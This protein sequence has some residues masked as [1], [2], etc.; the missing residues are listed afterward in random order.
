MPELWKVLPSI[1]NRYGPVP[2][3]AEALIEP[4]SVLHVGCVAVA[5]RLKVLTVD[6]KDCS[7]YRTLK[8]KVIRCEFPPPD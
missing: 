4:R 1:E 8:G 7:V 3:E 6:R 2:P 5:P